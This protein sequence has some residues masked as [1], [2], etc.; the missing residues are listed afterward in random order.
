GDTLWSPDLLVRLNPVRA[1]QSLAPPRF[2]GR[3]RVRGS[4]GLALRP[5]PT[6]PATVKPPESSGK[7]GGFLH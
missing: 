3:V 7:A 5:D 2:M 1:R 6:T 4:T